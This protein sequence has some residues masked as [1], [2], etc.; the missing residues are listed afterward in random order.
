MPRSPFEWP[1][2]IERLR[3]DPYD[4]VLSGST[5]FDIRSGCTV[6]IGHGDQLTIRSDAGSTS[7]T[8]TPAQASQI[9]S[10]IECWRLRYGLLR[11]GEQH[12]D[13]LDWRW[14][15]ALAR[16]WRRHVHNASRS[17]ACGESALV[18]YGLT[19]AGID[20]AGRRGGDGPPF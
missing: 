14:P 3:D 8:V 15:R 12:S 2:L 6:D 4:F 10:D 17:C 16:W 13:N 18:L 11:Q 9:R 7:V 1:T 19:W 5:I 20:R